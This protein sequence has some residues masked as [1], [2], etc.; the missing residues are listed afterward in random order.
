M[1][2]RELRPIAASISGAASGGANL[3]FL[4]TSDRFVSGERDFFFEEFRFLFLASSSLRIQRRHTCQCDSWLEH[5][6]LTI[7]HRLIKLKLT[8]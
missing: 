5:I 7:L 1:G 4:G 3:D 8:H 6:Y 2:G